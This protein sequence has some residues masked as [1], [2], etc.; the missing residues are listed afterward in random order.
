MKKALVFMANGFEE[1]EAC[2][3][4]DIL[5]RAQVHVDMC[6]IH[7]TLEVEGAHGIRMVSD[8]RL[9]DIADVNRY[10]A[11][12]IPG[13]MPGAT[14]L[15]DN[16]FVV[17]SVNTFFDKPGKWIASICAAPIVLGKAG[18][19]ADLAGTCY[20]GYEE[21]AGYGKY[22]KEP[23]VCEKNVVTSMGPGTALC[24][25]IKLAELLQGEEVAN[26]LF[27]GMLLRYSLPLE[28]GGKL[29]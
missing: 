26:A 22:L 21:Q 15:R 10:D 14:N 23:V 7:D 9:S 11:I 12:V 19:T 13:G 16:S 28:R 24:L 20:P 4:I 6:S 1:I 2:S 3:L 5:R 18:I 17:D 8:I 29:S 27:E 25:G